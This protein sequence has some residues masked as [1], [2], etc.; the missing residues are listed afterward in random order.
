VTERRG[1]IGL[2]AGL[3]G[4]ALGALAA[5]SDIVLFAVLAGAM[6]LIAGVAAYRLWQL[7]REATRKV[8]ALSEQV[9]ELEHERANQA[10]RD[11]SDSKIDEAALAERVRARAK[12]QSANGEETLT[13]AETGLFSEAYFLVAVDARSAA[14]RRHLRP[15]AVVLIEVIAGLG[16]DEP[17]A[18]NPSKVATSIT[19][20]LREA[21]TACRLADGTYALL[22]EDTPEN[23][24]I[25]TVER[26][27]RQMSQDE[28][29]LTMWAGVS[30][31]PA[32][33]FEPTELLE[34]ATSAL[35]HAR[36]WRQDRI[37][38]AG[39]SS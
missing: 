10:N 14:A 16:R 33:G 28:P 39:A 8:G 7:A 36:E 32:H 22:L 18:A 5:L 2:A 3:L 30:C 23:G 29:E 38:V 17:R 31:Y 35:D 11:A 1:L 27:R 24:A 25:W 15:V 9:S 12:R 37:E 6:A 4:L 34:A 20:T 26:L 21:D 13:D 19:T